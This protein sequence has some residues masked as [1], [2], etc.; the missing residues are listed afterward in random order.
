MTR[1][2][3]SLCPTLAVVALYGLLLAVAG[4]GVSVAVETATGLLEVV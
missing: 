3:A 2:F 4:V 1:L